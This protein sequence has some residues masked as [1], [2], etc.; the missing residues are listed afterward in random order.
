MNALD[1]AKRNDELITEIQEAID[2]VRLR[3]FDEEDANELTYAMLALEIVRRRTI[4]VRNPYL[5]WFHRI[6]GDG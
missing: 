3:C 1:E 5:R 6:V 4:R 2:R